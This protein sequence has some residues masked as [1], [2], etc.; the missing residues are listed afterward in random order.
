[1]PEREREREFKH[2]LFNLSDSLAGKGE[3]VAGIAD[4]VGR[5]GVVEDRGDGEQALRIKSKDLMKNYPNFD[6]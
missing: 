5:A 6:Y 4:G 2:T 3:V 1:M